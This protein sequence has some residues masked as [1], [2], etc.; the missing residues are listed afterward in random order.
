MLPSIIGEAMAYFRIVLVSSVQHVKLY[1]LQFQRGIPLDEMRARQL[2]D[3]ISRCR[4]H[5]GCVVVTLNTE[6]LCC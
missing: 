4:E 3:E 6:T 2:S 5:L 1:S